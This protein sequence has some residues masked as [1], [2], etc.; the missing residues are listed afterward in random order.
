MNDFFEARIP[1]GDPLRQAYS[2]Q[3]LFETAVGA[4]TIEGWIDLEFGQPLGVLGEGFFQPEKSLVF[5]SQADGHPCLC[6][7]PKGGVNRRSNS[8]LTNDPKRQESLSAC[9]HPELRQDVVCGRDPP[10]KLSRRRD[11]PRRRVPDRRQVPPR[12]GRKLSHSF[13]PRR[14]PVNR[15]RDGRKSF[16]RRTREHRPCARGNLHG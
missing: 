11:S 4:Q 13:T 12:R 1:R 8:T 2:L 5:F 10:A 7:H 14:L 9:S 3:Q 16:A 15:S 6:A